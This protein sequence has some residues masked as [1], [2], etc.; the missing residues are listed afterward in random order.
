MLKHGILGLLN[1]EEMTGYEIMEAFRDSLGFFWKAQTS[2][3]YRELGKLEEK[4]WV[5]KTCVPQRGR[6]DKNV[7][8]ITDRGRHE[9]LFWLSNGDLCLEQRVP[10]LMK[11]FFMGELS[12][13]QSISFFESLRASCELFLGFLDMAMD[14]IG[15]YASHLGLENDPVYWAMTVEYGKMM[16][17]M[18][19]D[20]AGK[21]IDRLNGADS[22]EHTGD[23][24]QSQGEPEQQL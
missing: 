1:Y 9:L 3:I 4:G 22:D 13:E 20:W 17:Q 6:P 11:V 16:M 10:L 21:C 18:N 23:K 14:N 2:Q 19:I 24:R 5:T 7:F 15:T 8:A 12:A